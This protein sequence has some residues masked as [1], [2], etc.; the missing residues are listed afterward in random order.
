ML[1]WTV[2]K[3]HILLRMQNKKIT[4][5]K[6]FWD[7]CQSGIRPTWNAMQAS[8][9]SC[10]LWTTSWFMSCFRRLYHYSVHI[11]SALMRMSLFLG[12]YY[13]VARRRL[14][15]SQTYTIE[16]TSENSE[17]LIR[18]LISSLLRQSC[19][20]VVI[21]HRVLHET[22]VHE[23]KWIPENTWENTKIRQQTFINV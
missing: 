22:V 12:V 13:R 1:K 3:S 10:M 18:R 2:V 4:N 16:F 6:H 21:W 20:A 15:V 5:L 19:S 23:T 9:R 8:I 14:K 11:F 7:T 17:G